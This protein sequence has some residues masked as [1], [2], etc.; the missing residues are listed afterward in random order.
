MHYQ[1]VK[2]Y[3]TPDDKKG[4]HIP[5]EEKFWKRVDKNGENVTNVGSP[6]WVWTGFKQKGYGVVWVD[7]KN[8]RAHRASWEMANGQIPDELKVLHKCD[9]PS[10]VNPEH[11]FLGTDK[12]NAQDKVQKGRAFVGDKRGEK[13]GKA[14]LTNEIVMAIRSDSGPYL[15]LA[16]LY[17]VDLS[18][19]SDIKRRKTW[20][21][22]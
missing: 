11:L 17:Q 2:H 21:H 8:V 1:R 13:A 16:N 5:L 10:C 19:I 6:C 4:D 15:P 3:G 9:N 20:A 18:T 7:G 14:K 22:I 12:D